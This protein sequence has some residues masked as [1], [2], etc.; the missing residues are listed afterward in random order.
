MYFS[1]EAFVAM[2]KVQVESLAAAARIVSDT[3]ERL[4]RLNLDSASRAARDV[5]A[6]LHAAAEGKAPASAVPAAVD[7]F[8]SYTRG[9]LEILH[10]AQGEWVQLVD[11]GMARFNRDVL[12]T[13]E[14]SVLNS[15]PGGDAV[16]SGLRNAMG[17][18]TSSMD[19]VQQMFKQATEFAEAS[20]KAATAPVDTGLKVVS[21]KRAA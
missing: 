1:N 13:V 4:G 20:L 19:A 14:R 16:V 6:T 8:G 21:R 7:T 5:I 11:A 10:E 3:S 12:E 2:N 15:V 18:T 9:L 17:A